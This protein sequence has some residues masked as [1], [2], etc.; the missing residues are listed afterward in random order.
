M[1]N[2]IE[3]APHEDPLVA[4]AVFL[5]SIVVVQEHLG[6]EGDTSSQP[7]LPR[8]P[9]PITATAADVPGRAAA[10]PRDPAGRTHRGA[11]PV[12][13]CETTTRRRHS[14]KSEWRGA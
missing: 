5:L 7:K 8:T 13:A 10:D 2:S 1:L 3:R 6:D 11:P 14:T 9:A 12:C 4:G